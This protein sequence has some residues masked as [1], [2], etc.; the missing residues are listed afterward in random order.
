MITKNLSILFIL[1]NFLI[2]INSNEINFLIENENDI[3]YFSLNEEFQVVAGKNESLIAWG[4][5]KDELFKDG[6]GKLYI[7]TNSMIT[8]DLAFKGAGFLESYLTWEYIYNFSINYFNSQFNTSNV[9]E[10]P[11]E[12]VNFV[13]ENIEFMKNQLNENSEESGYWLQVS[14]AL[15]QLNG[16]YLGYNSAA[17]YE[18]QLSFLE[19]YLINLYGDIEDIQSAVSQQNHSFSEMNRKELEEFMVTTGHCTTLIKL[20]DN[21][22]DLMVGHTTWSQYTDMIRIYKR[23]KIPVA[24]TPYGYETLFASYPGLLVSIDDF[25]MI[26]PSKLQLTETLNSILNQT[27][28]NRI[29]PQSFLYWIRNLVA[30]RLSNSGFEWIENFVPFNSGTNNIQFMIV[31]Y[32]LFK[33]SQPLVAGTLWIVEQYPIGYVASDQTFTL[34]QQQYWPSYNRPY[35]LEIFDLMGYSYYEQL[36]GNLFSYEYNPRANIF[37][38][39]QSQVENLSDLQYLI[40][41]NQY[42][43]DPLSFGYP[44]N[45]IAARYDLGGSPYEPSSWF[46]KGAW[47]GIDGKVMN[48][49]MFETFTTF[50]RNGPTVNDECPPFTW[51]NWENV[52]HQGLPRIFNFT[53]IEIDFYFKTLFSKSLDLKENI[54]GYRFQ[55]D[56]NNKIN[57]LVT[58]LYET[59]YLINE[60]NGD[61]DSKDYLEFSVDSLECGTLLN[62]NVDRIKQI[63]SS[64]LNHKIVISNGL[65]Q[66]ILNQ[67]FNNFSAVLGKLDDGEMNGVKELI[68][69]KI[70]VLEEGKDINPYNFEGLNC[71][72]I[73]VPIGGT[74]IQNINNSNDNSSNN[75]NN[76]NN[77]QGGELQ[78][79]T[80]GVKF[81][82]S[83]QQYKENNKSKYTLQWF[84]FLPNQPFSQNYRILPMVSGMRM[85]L[86]LKFSCYEVS[87]FLF[88]SDRLSIYDDQHESHISDEPISCIREISQPQFNIDNSKQKDEVLK[89]LADRLK[90]EILV[91]E[92]VKSFGLVLNNLYPNNPKDSEIIGIDSHLWNLLKLKF[93]NQVE[94]QTF[95]IQNF[96]QDEQNLPEDEIYNHYSNFRLDL[97]DNY[98]LKNGPHQHSQT[99]MHLYI[100]SR[101]GEIRAFQSKLPIHGYDFDNISCLSVL[102]I[103]NTV[104]KDITY[105]DACIVEYI[106]LHNFFKMA[107]ANDVQIKNRCLFSANPNDSQ[108]DNNNNGN[109]NNIDQTIPKLISK[110]YKPSILVGEFEMDFENMDPSYIDTININGEDF[111]TFLEPNIEKLKSISKPLADGNGHEILFNKKYECK[112]G[113]FVYNVHGNLLKISNFIVINQSAKRIIILENMN[114]PLKLNSHRQE[115]EIGT[116][117]LPIGTSNIETGGDHHVS[118]DGNSFIYKPYINGESKTLYWLATYFDDDGCTHTISPVKK[119]TKIFIELEIFHKYQEKDDWGFGI[120]SWSY[121]D[122]TRT[123]P[124]YQFQIPPIPNPYLSV[125]CGDRTYQLINQLS[126]RILDIL[127]KNKY[128]VAIVL[129]HVY[130]HTIGN[131]NL[132]GVDSIIWKELNKISPI[133][134][135]LK[136]FYISTYHSLRVFNGT[137]FNVFMYD[138]NQIVDPD[139]DTLLFSS[140]QYGCIPHLYSSNRAR[141]TDITCISSILISNK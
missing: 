74:S 31:D 39:R 124:S 75:N 129:E 63:Y 48:S 84:S 32:K 82:L 91:D 6:W 137:E 22:T 118:Y 15:E 64:G 35:S 18:Y 96:S 58:E 117:I 94:I 105:T 130:P 77:R 139:Q 81:N 56:P 68:P 132:Q 90:S 125:K 28:Y 126:E 111:G 106:K 115:N 47:G 101:Y 36:Y 10:F 140:S 138:G 38:Q 113:K 2:I 89:L 19:I 121:F 49:K 4:Y 8:D 7:E 3:E 69:H 54:S 40:S 104:K 79:L 78:S 60:I 65:S 122:D 108:L 100:S 110:I 66:N 116:L 25:Y 23:I 119:G 127:S 72:N 13:Y 5:F 12:V 136:H 120:K 21:N 135:Q 98:T 97:V 61:I 76:N 20:T 93:P 107:L 51:S 131:N 1:F 43:S 80:T 45:A 30:N 16:I 123:G 11:V 85:Y 37:K 112:I 57:K 44:G 50:A 9:N 134:I 87:E 53:W 95:T 141:Y 52:I 41:Y 46:Y 24:S 14:N 83:F 55:N 70:I 62:P 34:I 26:R 73:L 103:N 59:P 128:Q 133:Q 17:P 29:T 27:L 42:K 33:P 86:H 92:N 109:N 88:I 67:L 99:Q 71:I 114:K 102:V